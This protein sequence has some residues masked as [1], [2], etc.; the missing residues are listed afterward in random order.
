MEDSLALCLVTQLSHAISKCDIDSLS[1]ENILNDVFDLISCLKGQPI[2]SS[3]ERMI[4]ILLIRLAKISKHT[5]DLIFLSLVRQFDFMRD[6]ID[7]WFEM[8]DGNFGKAFMVGML[9][10]DLVNPTKIVATD[11]L[12]ILKTYKLLSKNNPAKEFKV[13]KFLCQLCDVIRSSPSNYPW[14]EKFM[15]EIVSMGSQTIM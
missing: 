1:I 10:C 11:L 9:E 12:S 3:A 5:H 8:I 2:K 15:M 6:D 4:I 7:Y 13:F 14:E